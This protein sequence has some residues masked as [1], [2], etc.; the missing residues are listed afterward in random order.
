MS[1]KSYYRAVAD[2]MNKSD[3]GGFRPFRNTNSDTCE[4]L[5][6]ITNIY[7]GQLLTKNDDGLAVVASKDSE[8]IL[9]IS[10][11]NAAKKSKKEIARISYYYGVGSLFY[12]HQSLFLDPSRELQSGKFLTHDNYGMYK[13]HD[14]SVNNSI[15]QIISPPGFLET[16]IP[17]LDKGGY[18]LIRTYI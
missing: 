8:W 5:I 2:S 16:G 14:G 12:I 11:E 17:G 4:C 3:V 10:G 15:A 9:G 6:G 18:V 1:I 13:I 7:Q